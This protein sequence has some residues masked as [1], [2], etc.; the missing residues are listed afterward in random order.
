MF[1]FALGERARTEE[2]RNVKASSNGLSIN[3]WRFVKGVFQSIR[4]M[5]QFVRSFRDEAAGSP[6]RATHPAAFPLHIMAKSLAETRGV[7]IPE[8]PESMERQDSENPSS[9]PLAS[10]PLSIDEQNDDPV[11]QSTTRKKC[12]S[13]NTSCPQFLG[14][15]SCPIGKTCT[16]MCGP[17][18]T[19]WEWI[20]GDCCAYE[21]CLNHDLHCGSNYVQCTLNFWEFFDG[22]CSRYYYDPGSVSS[23]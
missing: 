15:T 8:I 6:T 22:S 13:Y 23:A 14:F 11:L 1:G 21:G 7:E 17:K 4:P 5:V 10:L 16:G 20:C 9:E 2:R 12:S 19:C 18:C 3:G